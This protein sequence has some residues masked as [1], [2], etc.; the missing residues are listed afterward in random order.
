MTMTTVKTAQDSPS[1]IGDLVRSSTAKETIGDKQFSNWTD[2]EGYYLVRGKFTTNHAEYNL[3]KMGKLILDTV[4][5]KCFYMT[6]RRARATQDN[7]NTSDL[8]YFLLFID[9]IMH[10]EQDNM[11]IVGDEGECELYT[12][13]GQLEAFD[14]S[15]KSVLVPSRLE[16]RV[17]YDQSGNITNASIKLCPIRQINEEQKSRIIALSARLAL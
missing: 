7:F 12:W 14:M 13:N 4:N 5:R 3:P 6:I 10:N 9:D 11:R 15:N 17:I 2:P 8:D 16:V 1:L